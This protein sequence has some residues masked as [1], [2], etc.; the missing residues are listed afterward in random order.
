MLPFWNSTR[1]ALVETL[2]G[3]LEKLGYLPMADDDPFVWMYQHCRACVGFGEFDCLPFYIHPQKASVDLGANI[4]HDSILLAALT[5]RVLA[6]EA[7]AEH[8]FLEENLPANCVVAI[9]AV[10]NETG[11]QVI[12][13]PRVDGKRM[14]GLSSLHD[15]SAFGYP[16]YDTETVRVR[17]LDAIVQER[18]ANEPIGFI[19]IDVE[20]HERAAIEGA[21]ETLERHRPNL[22]VEIWERDV[23]ETRALLEALGYRGLFYFDD[24]LCDLSAF[25]PAVHCAPE[26]QWRPDR[27]DFNPKLLV[28]NFFF[29]PVG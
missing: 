24:R 9:E 7:L 3:R 27:D 10:G 20:G 25:D 29:V 28:N 8:A 2:A 19:K 11:K 21:R 1:E 23:P 4:G 14:T 26:N 15:P 12:H 6:V 17:P 18:F 5:R 16:E 22:Q 13:V